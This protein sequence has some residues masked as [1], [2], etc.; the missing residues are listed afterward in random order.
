MVLACQNIS[1]AFGTDKILEN[2][3]FHI[4][5]YEKCAI[6]GI[7]GAGK[8]TL[9]KIIAGEMSAD[10]GQ[11][12]ISKDKTLGYLSQQQNLDPANTIY[13]EVLSVKAGVIA[14]ETN[15]RRIMVAP[16]FSSEAFA[17]LFFVGYNS[18][19]GN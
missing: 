14:M 5:E 3:S 11:V 1:K 10:S 4:N 12:A 18:N 13:D 15:L 9:L 16:F 6:V 19:C 7:N 2:I 8:S 17:I